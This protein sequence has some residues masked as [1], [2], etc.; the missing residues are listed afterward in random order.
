MKKLFMMLLILFIIY[1]GIQL[2][3]RFF[4]SGH[5][6]EYILTSG[7]N[8]FQVK[9]K[10]INNTKGEID[11]YYFE[12][13]VN[14][15]LFSYQTYQ[16]F[17]NAN[18]IIKD[19]IYYKDNDYNCILPIFM[20]EKI[21]SDVM[22]LKNGIIY[23]YHDIKGKNS[24]LDL[25]VDSLNKYGYDVNKWHD[26]ATSNYVENLNFYSENAINNHFLAISSYK[27]IYVINGASAYKLKKIDIFTN[28]TYK[29]PVSIVFKNYYVVADYNAQ[30]RF[31]KFYI[32]DLTTYKVNELNCE[33]EIS[34]DSYIQGTNNNSIYLFDRDNKKQYEI[35]LKTNKVLEVGNENTDI[36]IYRNG[37]W[38]KISAINAKNT[39]ILFDT[40]YKSDIEISK[41]IKID[42]VGGETAGY[43]Y[44]YEKKGSEYLVYRAPV[45]NSS[46]L[47]YVFNTTDINRVVY[48]QDYVYYIYGSEIRS[49]NEQ[50]G[51]RT[52]IQDKELSFNE[53]LIFG[54]YVK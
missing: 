7:E 47:T 32:V 39:T 42:K 17:N 50:L 35:N 25:F 14:D 41:Y 16:S 54:L 4:G 10:F 44:F 43:Y 2:G 52:L 5:E 8:S 49:F 22:C 3:F 6:Y 33:R 46:N 36:K 31:D 12:I 30:Y 15:T 34:L 38:E 53:N 1:I 48:Y 24:N 29:R 11:S 45:L 27:G 40:E 37:A 20:N 13:S 23:N 21:I 26:T 51:V 9:E 19:I 18:H 28:D